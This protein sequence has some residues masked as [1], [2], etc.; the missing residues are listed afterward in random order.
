MIAINIR[1]AKSH[2]SQY[3][4]KVL[5]GEKVIFCIRNKPAVEL[6]PIAGKQNIKIGLAKGKF[7][8]PEDFNSPLS[9]KET[10]TFYEGPLFNA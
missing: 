9:E 6:R 7:K 1:E 5:H 10:E 4:K 2:L 8:T 3:I